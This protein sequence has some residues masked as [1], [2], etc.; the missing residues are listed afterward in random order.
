ME[1]LLAFL[2]NPRYKLSVIMDFIEKYILQ[3]KKDYD[4]GFDIP[5]LLT[6][7]FNSHPSSAINFIKEGRTDYSRLQQELMDMD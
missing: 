5:Y 4:L 3:M 7:I 6:G 2:K 1:S